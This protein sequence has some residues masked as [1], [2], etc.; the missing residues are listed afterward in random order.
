MQWV[1]DEQGR[2]KDKVVLGVVVAAM[3]LGLLLYSA[4]PTSAG[5]TRSATPVARIGG[6]AVTAEAPAATTPTVPSISPVSGSSSFTAAVVRTASAT[7]VVHEA[8]NA[9]TTPSAPATPSVPST[10]STPSTPSAPAAPEAACP[11][12]TA[13][14]AY[15]SVADPLAEAIGE[16]VPRDN[17][18]LLTEIAAGCSDDTPTTPLL[19][20]ALD[21]ARLVPST[22]LPNQDLSAIPP[23]PA[24]ALPEQVIDALAPLNDQIMEACGNVGLLGVIVAVVPSTAGIPVNGS[25]LADLLVPAQTLCAQFEPDPA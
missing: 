19:G 10:P 8:L 20:L 14:D 22:G 13:S 5:P 16:R 4:V 6:G 17:L 12:A 3:A 15:E 23:V 21:L 24:P 25:D 1:Q 2:I 9:P 18:R 11:T 7:R